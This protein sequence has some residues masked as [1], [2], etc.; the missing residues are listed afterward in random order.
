MELYL[1]F[2]IIV[3]EVLWFFILNI[4]EYVDIINI[5]LV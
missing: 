2:L 4:V 3:L 5:K 1:G